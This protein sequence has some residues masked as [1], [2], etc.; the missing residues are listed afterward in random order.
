MRYSDPSGHC[1]TV[2]NGV[3]IIMGNGWTVDGLGFMDNQNRSM[4]SGQAFISSAAAHAVLDVMG[5]I[6]GFGEIADAANALLY[7]VEGDWINAAISAAAIVPAVGSAGTA[8]RR[9]CDDVAGALASKGDEAADALT[10]VRPKPGSSGGPTA[11]NAFPDSVKEA[12]KAENMA[13]TG[14]DSPT[15][16][17]CLME[18][19]TPHIDHAIP[20]S[21]HGN[22]TL[23]NAQVACAHCNLSRGNRPGPVTPPPGYEGPWPLSHWPS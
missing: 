17:W 21:K 9:F 14:A 10:G 20:K 22:A 13:I 7:A 8:C 15:C 16:V 4:Y 1:T 3:C 11:G 19:D 18:S 5:L 23:D 2:E 6:P 12:A